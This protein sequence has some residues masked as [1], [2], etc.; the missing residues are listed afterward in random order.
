MPKFSKKCNAAI[1]GVYPRDQMEDYC[2]RY[3][4]GYMSNTGECF[5]IGNTTSDASTAFTR[6]GELNWGFFAPDSACTGSF[7]PLS[8]VAAY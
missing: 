8:P 7:M 5:D 3:K 6:T 4:E 1:S 2:R